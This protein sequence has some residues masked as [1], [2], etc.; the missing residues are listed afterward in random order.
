MSADTYQELKLRM[1]AILSEL[2]S[3]RSDMTIAVAERPDIQELYW[4]MQDAMDNLLN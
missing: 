2:I 1:E 3:I 4:D